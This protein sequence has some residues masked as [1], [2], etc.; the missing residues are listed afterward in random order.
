MDNIDV[1]T[2]YWSAS[3]GCSVV[4]SGKVTPKSQDK[5]L[6]NYIHL[7]H[8]LLNPF[9]IV[10][11]AK[12]VIAQIKS[13]FNLSLLHVDK[14]VHRI[15]NPRSDSVNSREMWG[16]HLFLG[17][18]VRPNPWVRRPLWWTWQMKFNTRLNSIPP[19]KYIDGIVSK[20]LIF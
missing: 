6:H 20:Q 10:R 7:L 1:G 13:G 15:L 17:G 11:L 5:L 12:V 9:H 4:R 8:R 2:E 19:Q 14:S 3:E 18:M 16:L